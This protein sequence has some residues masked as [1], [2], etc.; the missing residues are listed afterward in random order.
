MSILTL[1]VLLAG[2]ALLSLYLSPDLL[3]RILQALKWSSPEAPNEFRT[4]Q[5]LL[6]VGAYLC[7]VIS[8]GFGWATLLALGFLAYR[9]LRPRA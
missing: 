4:I 7:F 2:V 9:F 1:L 8:L 5:V 6:A 3:T